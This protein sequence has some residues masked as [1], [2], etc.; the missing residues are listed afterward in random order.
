[1]CSMGEYQKSCTPLRDSM[2]GVAIEDHG[3]LKT[4]VQRFQSC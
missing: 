1:M 4:S 3:K 2:E